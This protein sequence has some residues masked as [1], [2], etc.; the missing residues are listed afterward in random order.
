MQ[1][2]LKADDEGESGDQLKGNWAWGQCQDIEPW[3][4]KTKK[5]CDPIPVLPFGLKT[6]PESSLEPP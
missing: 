1:V 2:L 6:G 3:G 5:G 4:G